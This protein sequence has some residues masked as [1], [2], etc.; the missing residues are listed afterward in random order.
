VRQ[1]AAEALGK[2][3]DSKAVGPLIAVLKESYVD[4]SAAKAL[5]KIGIPSVDP[6]IVVLRDSDRQYASPGSRS[7]GKNR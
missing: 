4:R 7:V 6:L 1:S 5:V 3:G 2:I